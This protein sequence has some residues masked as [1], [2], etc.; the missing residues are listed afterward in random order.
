MTVIRIRAMVSILVALA[1]TSP[2]TLAAV[3]YDG[4]APDQGGQIY[5]EG[6]AS[7]AMSFSLAAGSNQVNSAQWWGGCF[8]SVTCG[9]APDFKLSFFADASGLPGALIATFDVGVANQTATGASIGPVGGQWN[10]YVYSASFATQLFT[11]GTTYWFGIN[12]AAAQPSGT[13]GVESTSSAPS[14]ASAASIGIFSTTDWTA[15]PGTLAFNLS[16]TPASVPEPGTLG[17][18]LAGLGSLC[19]ARRRQTC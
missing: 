1:L 2:P 10:E 12:E 11:P 14:G 5:A 9:P 4:G 13:W 19:W 16:Y 7:V 6:A 15:I 17:L 18:L 3:V 8:P